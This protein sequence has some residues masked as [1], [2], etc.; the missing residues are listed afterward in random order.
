MDALNAWEQIPR[1]EFMC[2]CQ[3]H[4]SSCPVRPA[5]YLALY[6][7]VV[8][9]TRLSGQF[10]NAPQLYYQHYGSR[11][12]CSFYDWRQTDFESFHEAQRVCITDW[13]DKSITD[14]GHLC[15]FVEIA[16]LLYSSVAMW[17]E[18]RWSTA[19]SCLAG[20]RPGSYDAASRFGELQDSRTRCRYEQRTHST[21]DSHLLR[22]N[23]LKT[24]RH[25]AIHC[26][27]W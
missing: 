11:V 2:C 17:S 12:R 22:L 19:R 3:I 23:P 20:V 14:V 10:G 24:L 16:Y 5:E 13:V 26:T 15:W 21:P 27:S 18:T 4:T 6:K 8:F 1:H 9:L 25:W 7:L